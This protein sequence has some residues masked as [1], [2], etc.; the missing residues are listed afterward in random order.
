MAVTG[1]ATSKE[2]KCHEYSANFDQI[3]NSMVTLFSIG[4]LD[5]WIED[6]NRIRNEVEGVSAATTYIFMISFLL[7]MTFVMLNVFVGFIAV[8]FQ[9]ERDKKDGFCILDKHAKDCVRMALHM[10]MERSQWHGSKWQKKIRGW[11]ETHYFEY[12]V[13]LCVILNCAVMMTKH[14]N[15]P[16]IYKTIQESANLLFTSLFTVECALKIYAMSPKGFIRDTWSVFDFLLV[17]GS[18]VDITLQLFEINIRINLTVFRL[19]RAIRVFRV[20]CKKGNLRQILETFLSSVKS[21]P[22]IVF[23]VIMV[24]FIYAVMGMQV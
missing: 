22:N 14:H 7:M 5:N 19:F 1:N 24:L 18:W 20:L 13:L 16:V 17:A 10:N 2:T 4:T 23:L 3:V 15:Q 6:L 12:T 21:V 11:L 9:M 8:A